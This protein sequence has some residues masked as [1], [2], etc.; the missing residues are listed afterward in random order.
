MGCGAQVHEKKYKIGTWAY[1][2]V[3]G[4]YLFTLPEHYRTHVCQVKA[5]KSE[6][7]TNTLQLTHKHITNPTITHA[8]KVMNAIAACAATLGGVAGGNTSQELQDL[9]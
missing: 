5:A 3:D 6:R 7:V 4:W 9:Q 1:H 2:S 8:D